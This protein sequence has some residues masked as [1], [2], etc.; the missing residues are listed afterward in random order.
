MTLIDI[1]IIITINKRSSAVS[2]RH[3]V[4]RPVL[5]AMLYTI[6][7]DI[8]LFIEPNLFY[9]FGVSIRTLLSTPFHTLDP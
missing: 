5:S 2:T 9:Y 8:F 1:E 4:Q 6:R 7:I 3:I